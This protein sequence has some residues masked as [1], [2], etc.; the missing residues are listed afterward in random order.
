MNYEDYHSFDPFSEESLR[1]VEQVEALP[2]NDDFEQLLYENRLDRTTRY[3]FN[4]N[5]YSEYDETPLVIDS[6]VMATRFPDE[7]RGIFPE[8]QY[9]IEQLEIEQI[10]TGPDVASK[11]LPRTTL[12][13]SFW[14]HQGQHVVKIEDGIAK[15]QTSDNELD[16]VSYT[17][18]PEVIIGLIAVFVLAK[19]Y[20][21]D[22][23]NQAI[24]LSTSSLGANRDPRVASVEEL[25]MTLGNFSGQSTLQT[26]AIFENFNG[27]PLI[28]TFIEKETPSKSLV[29]NEL[30]LN[31]LSELNQMIT[32][33]ETSISQKSK[34]DSRSN[35][36][37]DFD[38]MSFAKQ[39][40]T[41]L[42]ALPF[43]T[44]ESINPKANH[45]RWVSVCASFLRIIEQRTNQS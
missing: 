12:L 43:T 39:R 26:R 31:E 29:S 34:L 21:P 15:Y 7:L 10:E 22:H 13:M 14:T 30:V 36:K 28:A 35:P 6:D 32:S 11:T 33:T 4:H 18:Q 17:F 27:T 24:E 37:I 8:D 5:K 16:P 19:Q 44:T 2:F 25:V 9:T 20:D 40:S 38:H 23:P 45:S 42:M 41:V 3:E 1:I